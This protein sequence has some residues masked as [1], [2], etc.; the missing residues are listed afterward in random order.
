[1]TTP[2]PVPVTIVVAATDTEVIGVGNDLP[3]H[4]RAD[5]QRFKRMTIG[6]P[7][8]VGRLTHESITARLGRP[9]PGRYVVVVTSVPATAGG[10]PHV[11]S[12]P[13]ALELA[14][15]AAGPDGEVFVIGGVGVY[16]AALPY[17]DRVE[18]TRV[19]ADVP[20][21]TVLPDG[22]LTGF[23]LV[24]SEP[25][26]ADEELP[27]TWLTYRRGDR[28][29]AE[30]P[31]RC[32]ETKEGRALWRTGMHP[33]TDHP[34]VECDPR[35]RF[36]APCI[37]R[38]RTADI[39]SMVLAGETVAAVADEFGL[40][41]G[42]VLVAVWHEGTHGH[43]RHRRRFGPWA[44]QVEELLAKAEPDYDAVPDPQVAGNVGAR[45]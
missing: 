15:A 31:V 30:G 21:D 14:R 9:M 6:R 4:L 33:V 37:G 28:K 19:H 1:V 39:A 25:G 8:V 11:P 45:S 36:G 27:Y 43:K 16:V 26:P 20:G 38:T 22:W 2:P 34:V 5:L 3:W 23:T 40:T 10:P 44:R 13:A 12:V 7:V 24:A 35:H 42:Q 41:R 18:L 29:P 17:V 32:R